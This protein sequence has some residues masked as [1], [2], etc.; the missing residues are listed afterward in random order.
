MDRLTDGAI[1]ARYA[2]GKEASLE[3]VM[4]RTLESF[5]IE[6]FCV[7]SFVESFSIVFGLN[8]FNRGEVRVFIELFVAYLWECCGGKGRNAEPCL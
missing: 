3:Q 6:S 5:C 8:W 4:R 1:D 2:I 7:E